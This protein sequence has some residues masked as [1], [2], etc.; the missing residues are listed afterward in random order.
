M[1]KVRIDAGICGNVTTAEVVCD[2]DLEAT[3]AVEST[4]GAVM[5]M[6]EEL[7]QVFDSY[8]LCLGKPG[9]GPLYE[10]TSENFPPHCGCPAISG[11]TK[12]VE[13]ESKLALPKDA[14]ISFS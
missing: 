13:A 9:T 3:L 14:T 8:S 4:C 11:I 6:F 12:A 2:E 7:G 5:K 10:Y 1:T